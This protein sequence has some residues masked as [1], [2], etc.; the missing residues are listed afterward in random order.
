MLYHPEKC[1]LIITEQSKNY[2]HVSKTESNSSSIIDTLLQ[3]YLSPL[4][5]ELK[6]QTFTQT[7]HFMPKGEAYII[8]TY[9]T[10]YTIVRIT[11]PARHE[12]TEEEEEFN[13]LYDD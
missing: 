12:L 5:T 4:Q 1:K 13:H 9:D 6:H 2:R 11:E 10:R 3:G 7:R 8:N